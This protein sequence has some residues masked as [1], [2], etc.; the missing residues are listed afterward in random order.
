M[1]LFVPDLSRREYKCHKCNKVYRQHQSLHRHIKYECGK[2]PGFFCL[3]SFCNYRAKQRETMKTHIR[4]KH[5]ELYD[6][7][8]KT[9]T[10]LHRAMPH[11][12]ISYNPFEK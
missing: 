7:F 2:E 9:N 8:M 10:A 12:D 4:L 3:H 5:S 11:Y 6:F 1:F